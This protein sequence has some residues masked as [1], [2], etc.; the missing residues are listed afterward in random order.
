VGARRKK[1]SLTPEEL[2][3]RLAHLDGTLS[4]VFGNERTG[5]T[6]AEMR[7]CDL[8]CRIPTSPRFPSLNLSHAV[9]IVGY[10][11]FRAEAVAKPSLHPIRRHRQETLVAGIV[12]SLKALGYFTLTDGS[13]TARLLRDVFSRAGLTEEEAGRI[14]RMFATIPHLAQRT[15]T[16]DD[17]ASPTE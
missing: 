16:R 15:P 1:F 6:D 7:L 10:V 5:L 3:G 4:L 17:A 12:A 2:V 8:A 9:Q 13:Y 14:E 11:F